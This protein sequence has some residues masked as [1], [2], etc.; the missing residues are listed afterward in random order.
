MNAWATVTTAPI[1]S[2]DSSYFDVNAIA[3]S[4]V[5]GI[6]DSLLEDRELRLGGIVVN[7]FLEQAIDALPEGIMLLA[8]QSLEEFLEV[9]RVGAAP[10]N[11]R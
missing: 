7:H 8:R 6:A 2:L 9:E 4:E 11:R 5:L 10:L 3:K 1:R